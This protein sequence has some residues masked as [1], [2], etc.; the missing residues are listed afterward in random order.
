MDNIHYLPKD[1]LFVMPGSGLDC[2]VG[3]SIVLYLLWWIPY[4]CFMLLVGIDLP[5][6]FREDGVTPKSPKYDTVFHR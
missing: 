5:K 1:G 4:V 3:N 6:K 2:V